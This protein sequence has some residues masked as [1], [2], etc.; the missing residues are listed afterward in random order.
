M[1]SEINSPNKP[2]NK[3]MINHQMLE[4]VNKITVFEL[5]IGRANLNNQIATVDPFFVN[6]TLR[7][8]KRNS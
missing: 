6:P 4:K 2:L 3:P 7:M 8:M 5:P 1:Y